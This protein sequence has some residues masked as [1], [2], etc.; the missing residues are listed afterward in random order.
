MVEKKPPARRSEPVVGAKTQRLDQTFLP[1]TT[2]R[3]GG[4]LTYATVATRNTTWA[5]GAAAAPPSFGEGSAALVA[6]ATPSTSTVAPGGTAAVEVAVQRLAKTAPA[7]KIVSKSRQ[8]GITVSGPTGALHFDSTGKGIVDLTIS[9]ASTVPSGYYEVAIRAAAGGDSAGTKATIRVAAAG[10]L[11]AAATI[12]GTSPENAPSG[13]FDGAGNSYSRDQ[14]VMLG[15]TPGATKVLANGTVLTWPSAPVG[16]PETI[17]ASGQTIILDK[18]ASTI[19]FVGAGTNGGEQG[20]ASVT[21]EDGTTDATADFSFG[22]WV[23]PSHDGRIV[24]GT[25]APVYGNT[26]VGWTPVRNATSSDPGAYL[27]ATTPFAAPA[28]K[29]I[30]S[31]TL[32]TAGNARLFGIATVE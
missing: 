14:L 24:D 19:S 16:R 7:Y 13:N 1:S 21:Y 2:L 23:I 30:V 26:T 15:L 5:T 25:L 27:F 20:T 22:D 10:S 29:H 31:V 6:N 11:S 3:N 12:V 18:P 28:G 4:T 17:M 32:P 8:T 9:V